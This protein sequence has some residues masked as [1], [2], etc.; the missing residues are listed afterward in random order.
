MSTGTGR[1]YGLGTVTIA[2]GYYISHHIKQG[3]NVLGVAVVKIDL[4]NLDEKWDREHGEMTVSDANGVIFL[5]SR[6]DWKYQPTQPLQQDTMEK[7][8]RTR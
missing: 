6:K 7:L 4:T 1:F 5:S 2:P 8:V 3:P